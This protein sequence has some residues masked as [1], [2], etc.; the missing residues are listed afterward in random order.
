MNA[1]YKYSVDLNEFVEKQR[2][3]EDALDGFDE[4]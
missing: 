3:F 1:S 2:I 4:N